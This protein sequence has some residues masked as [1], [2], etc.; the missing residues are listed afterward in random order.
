LA[1]GRLALEEFDRTPRDERSPFAEYGHGMMMRSLVTYEGEAARWDAVVARDA[2]GDGAFVFAVVTTGIYCRPSCPARQPLRKNV[3][4]F[5]TTQLA[6]RAGFR[7][8][9]RCKPTSFAGHDWLVTACRLLE[10]DEPL[11]NEV[12]AARVGVSRFH[13][14]HAFKQRVGVTPQAYRRRVRAERAKV[15]LSGAETVTRAAFE[16]GYGAPSRFYAEAGK[17]LGMAP[18][19]ARRGAEGESVAWTTASCSLGTVLVAWTDRGVC[20]VSLGDDPDDLIAELRERFPRAALAPSD[21]APPWVRM[22]IRACDHPSSCAI[23]LDIRGTAFQERVWRALREIPAGQTRTYSELAR[24]LGAPRSA[25]A[26]AAA[27]ASNRLAVVIPCHRVI[28]ED[29]TL[30]GYRWGLPR[31]RTLLARESR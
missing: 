14:L 17:E 9:L 10:Q 3:K 24:Q 25:R 5:D 6:E 12:I 28:R 30:A 15:L 13:F 2:R 7:A 1:D 18:R 4:F 23:P 19:A 11:G 22:V 8:C 31:K 29:Q 21:D 16:S 27:C 20:E 26:V